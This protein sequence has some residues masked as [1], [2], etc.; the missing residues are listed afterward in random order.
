LQWRSQQ[1]SVCSE[2]GTV[3]LA[4][5]S[6]ARRGRCAAEA[7][8]WAPGLGKT[9]GGWGW[10]EQAGAEADAQGEAS[11]ERGSA[12]KIALASQGRWLHT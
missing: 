10:E 9:Q 4:A 2:G 11:G 8:A 1:V 7:C 12:G 3:L 6:K 5:A